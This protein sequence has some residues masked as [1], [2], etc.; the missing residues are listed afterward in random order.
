MTSEF[1]SRISD[2]IGGIWDIY[3]FEYILTLITAFLVLSVAFFIFGIEFYYAVVPTLILA[4]VLYVRGKNAY[5]ALKEVEKGN[6]E[7]EDKLLAA[8][9]NK[10]KDN[11]IVR[12][13][14]RDVSYDLDYVNNEAFV[15]VKKINTY[16]MV[17]I[18]SVF[19]LLFLLFSDFEG[20]GFD[21]LLGGGGGSGGTQGDGSG[22]GSGGGGTGE[23]G[24]VESSQDLQSNPGPSQDIY[25]DSSTAKIDGQDTE[26]EIHPEYGE[27]G[28]FDSEES[29]GGDRVNEIRE[30]FTQAT[31][32]ETYTE[33]IPVEMEE[34]VRSY[35]EKITKN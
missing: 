23:E 1:E 19:L 15:N 6:P 27:N 25:G 5:E 8:Y 30:G 22:S 2:A 4:V 28:D 13:L 16:V 26:L 11:F 12:E 7:L 31:A 14:V 32:A 34:V 35:F 24:D 18:I 20:L 9:D 21:G 29:E 33:N 17:C 10:D 3:L